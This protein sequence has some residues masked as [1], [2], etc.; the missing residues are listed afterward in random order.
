[1]IQHFDMQNGLTASTVQ[2]VQT[3]IAVPQVLLRTRGA[4]AL[5]NTRVKC[6]S[7]CKSIQPAAITTTIDL[8]FPTVMTSPNSLRVLP[9]FRCGHF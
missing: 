4:E 1:M 6:P 7:S 5:K 9:E 3:V 2:K 8:S